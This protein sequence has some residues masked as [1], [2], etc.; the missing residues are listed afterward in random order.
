MSNIITL[1]YQQQ[2]LQVAPEI[3]AAIVK[4][5]V[6]CNG[7]YIDFLRPANAQA[8]ANKSIE[9]MSSFLMAPWAGRIHN[10]Q[11]FYQGKKIHY[12]SRLKNNPHSMHGFTRDFPWKVSAHS[13]NTLSL[14]FQHTASE[15]WPFSFLLKQHYRLCDSGLHIVVE[16]SNIGR[17]TMPFSLGHHPFFP[18]DEHTKVHTQVQQAWYSDKDLMPTY[19]ASHPLIRRLAEG[20]PV[21]EAAWD[22]IFTGWNKEVLITWADRS[23]RYQVS[24]PLNFFVLYNP[25]EKP[26]FCAEPFGNITDSF[27]LRGKFAD[28]LIGGIEMQAGEH[29]QIAFTLMPLLHEEV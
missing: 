13:E 9:D 24:D 29:R 27:N 17:D 20:Y 23:L 28:E 16:I 25:I 26:W 15:I 12:P 18:C 19:V 22:T 3:G 1:K 5:A 2:V 10:G 21:R 7:R 6:W 4:Y 8:I 14:E 11:F